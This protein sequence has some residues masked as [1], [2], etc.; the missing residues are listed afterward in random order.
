VIAL[1]LGLL[2]LTAGLLANQLLGGASQIAGRCTRRIGRGNR[3]DNDTRILA[4]HG[5]RIAIDRASCECRC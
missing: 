1:R 5:L 4:V 3:S 2:A